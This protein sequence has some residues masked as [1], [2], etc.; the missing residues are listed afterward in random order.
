VSI[1]DRIIAGVCTSEVNFHNA[2][3]LIDW[4]EDTDSHHG[5]ETCKNKDCVHA[6]GV[7]SADWAATLVSEAMFLCSCGEHGVDNPAE[8]ARVVAEFRAK[9]G[10]DMARPAIVTGKRERKVKR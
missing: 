3:R 9:W 6:P 4:I 1:I 7:M 5:P 10:Q 8:A 2:R